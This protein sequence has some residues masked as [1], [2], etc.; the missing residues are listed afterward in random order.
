M[1]GIEFM[2]VA[3]ALFIGAIVQG[4]LG[5]GMVLVSFPLVVFTEPELLPQTTMIV[6][7]PMVLTLAWRHRGPAVWREVGLLTLGRIPGIT[8]AVLILSVAS[9]RSIGLLAGATVLAAVAI[10]FW[11]PA[12]PRTT[13]NLLA[14]GTVSALFGTAVAIGGPPLALMF[15]HEEGA[16]LRSTMT[17]VMLFGAPLSLSVLA[18]TGQVSMV[19]LRTGL[20]LMPCSILG[21]YSARWVIPHVDDRLRPIVLGVCAFGAVVA[22]VRL[23]FS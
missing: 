20:A 21:S 11:A 7:I 15:Q 4:S 16:R 3:V 2:V 17:A 5:F 6:A 18:L 22:M 12:V 9:A 14:A 10:S 23:G 19:D 13:T 1:T 8:L